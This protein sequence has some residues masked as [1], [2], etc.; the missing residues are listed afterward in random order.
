MYALHCC[1]GD[2]LVSEEWMVGVAV[3]GCSSYVVGWCVD[4]GCGP[5]KDVLSGGESDKLD[6]GICNWSKVGLGR[7]S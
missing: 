3:V 4:R 7:G 1:D 6:S 2:V 5:I